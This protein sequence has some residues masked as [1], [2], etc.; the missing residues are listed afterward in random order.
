MNVVRSLARGQQVGQQ[1]GRERE[2]RQGGGGEG[3][4]WRG[5]LGAARGGRRREPVGAGLRPQQRLDAE[6]RL[7][8][9]ELGRLRRRLRV[10]PGDK[11]RTFDALLQKFCKGRAV[12]QLWKGG[13]KEPRALHGSRVGSL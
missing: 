7:V 12:I 13:F 5:G 11:P 3:G 10:P 4:G 1:L 9:L 8:V 2:L 6:R